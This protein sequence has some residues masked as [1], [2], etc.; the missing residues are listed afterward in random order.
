M[1]VHLLTA[2][3]MIILPGHSPGPWGSVLLPR[4]AP[5]LSPDGTFCRVTFT[6]TWRTE[7]LLSAQPHSAAPL[8]GVWPQMSVPHRRK[9]VPEGPKFPRRGAHSSG[10]GTRPQRGHAH[11]HQRSAMCLL[12]LGSGD[13][14]EQGQTDVGAQVLRAGTGCCPRDKHWEEGGCQHQET[15]LP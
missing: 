2:A 13:Q 9:L 3:A 12:Q 10:Q 5:S 6:H 1:S 11:L 4:G 15:L 8:P 14:E 7:L